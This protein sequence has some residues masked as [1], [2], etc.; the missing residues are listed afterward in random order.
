MGAPAQGRGAGKMADELNRGASRKL[1]V[2][3]LLP[4]SHAESYLYESIPGAAS[5]WIGVA[6]CGQ[7]QLLSGI[8]HIGLLLF[9]VCC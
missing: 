3:S 5:Y 6:G 4:S 8:Q 2:L 9:L 7:T 1:K